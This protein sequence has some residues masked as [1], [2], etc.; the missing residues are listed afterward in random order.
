M[1]LDTLTLA[2]GSIVTYEDTANPLTRYEVVERVQDR[3]ST[4]FRL[5][6]LDDDL[7][8]QLITSDCRQRGWTLVKDGAW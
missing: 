4:F 3:W 8:T 7:E 1:A 6:N 5:K 2:P